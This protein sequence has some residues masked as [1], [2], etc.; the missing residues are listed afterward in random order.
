MMQIREDGSFA[1]A[2]K[3]RIPEETPDIKR[4]KEEKDQHPRFKKITDKYDQVF[5][6]IGKETSRMGKISTPNSAS[7]RKQFQSPKSQDQSLT[8]FKNR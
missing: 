1:E 2:N 5:T 7:N 6:G 3:M 8:T 4:I